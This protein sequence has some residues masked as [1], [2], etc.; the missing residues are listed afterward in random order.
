M[1]GFLRLEPTDAA[2]VFAEIS[3]AENLMSVKNHLGHS[4][5]P[6]LN[7]NAIGDMAPGKG[8]HVKVI[9]DDVLRYAANDIG[10]DTFYH[11][12][13]E[14]FPDGEIGRLLALMQEVGR[15]V[16]NRTRGG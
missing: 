13:D 11:N 4:Y 7:Y 5:L 1:I 3:D 2:D 8:Y 6:H 12:G 16:R 10:I 14:G 15:G 9:E